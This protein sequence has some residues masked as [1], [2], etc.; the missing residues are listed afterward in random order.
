MR[1]K[2]KEAKSRRI[3]RKK[4]GEGSAPRGQKSGKDPD[5]SLSPRP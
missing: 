4:E 1:I 5:R 2:K 3:G